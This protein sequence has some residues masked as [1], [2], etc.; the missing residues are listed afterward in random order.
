M[1]SLK[2]SIDKLDREEQ[3]FQTTLDCYLAAISGI[4][5]YAVEVT[6]ELTE[7]HGLSLQ[8]LHRDLSDSPGVEIGRASCRERV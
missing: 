5:E 6:P 2:K 4:Y 8:A 3:R 1:F 7:T